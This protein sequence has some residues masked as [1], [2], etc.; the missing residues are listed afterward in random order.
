MR[1]GDSEGNWG[2]WLARNL[3]RIRNAV[4]FV[5]FGF[6]LV[7]GYIW[8]KKNGKVFDNNPCRKAFK[9]EVKGRVTSVFLDSN[10]RGR[11]SV[12]VVQLQGDT[13]EYYTGWGGQDA[14]PYIKNGYQ[15]S[16]PANSFDMEITNDSAKTIRFDAIVKGCE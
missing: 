15:F 14:G 12:L 6:C 11:V 9:T 7:Y 5:G 4:I 8:F 13:I 2:T 1:G 16:K 3:G 10:S